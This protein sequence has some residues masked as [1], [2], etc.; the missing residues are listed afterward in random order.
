MSEYY[1]PSW[2]FS[3]ETHVPPPALARQ[4]ARNSPH[5]WGNFNPNY[6]N[7]TVLPNTN[8]LGSVA[9]QPLPVS[10]LRGPFFSHFH[11]R[12]ATAGQRIRGQCPTKPSG[13]SLGNPEDVFKP[14][15]GPPRFGGRRISH[16]K[17]RSWKNKSHG[18][19]RD[20]WRDVVEAFSFSDAQ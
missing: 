13:Y 12:M 7:Y 9:P 5:P 11:T 18:D 2:P 1:N 6:P 16:G 14:T 4:S 17:L 8:D 19:F 20:V 3:G 15:I 10:L